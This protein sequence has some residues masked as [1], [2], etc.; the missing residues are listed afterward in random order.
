MDYDV[1][2]H[3]DARLSGDNSWLDRFTLD[4]ARYTH[5]IVIC[6]PFTPAMAVRDDSIFV[7]FRH[8]VHIG[9]NLT[10]VEALRGS[11][12]SKSCWSGTATGPR[13]RI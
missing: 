13:V 10:M 11:I 12:R 7:R 1:S 3:T 8:C 5:L 9:V 6:G 4:P 2:P